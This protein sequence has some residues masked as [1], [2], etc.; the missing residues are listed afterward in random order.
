MIVL[1]RLQVIKM[2]IFE[3]IKSKNIDEFTEWLDKYGAFDGSPWIEW[4]DK[5][6]CQKCEAEYAQLDYLEK[7]KNV[8]VLGVKY[9]KSANTFQ[10]KIESPII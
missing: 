9:I 7:K 10:I 3:S 2:T 5:T 4:F 1:M 6:Y 8:C